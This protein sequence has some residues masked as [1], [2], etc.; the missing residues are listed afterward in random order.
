MSS[1]AS[2]DSTKADAGKI[3]P[4]LPVIFTPA[5]EAEPDESETA[6]TETTAPPSRRPWTRHAPL[7]ASLA[8]ALLVGGLAGAAATASFM[9]GPSTHGAAEATHALQHSVVQLSTEI[10]ALK[11]SV[12][13]AQRTTNTQF[14]KF[15]ARLDRTEKAQTEPT[16]KLAKLQESVDALAKQQQTA[17]AAAAPPAAASA[18]ITGSVAAKQDT[19]PALDGWRLRDFYSGRAVVES[20]AGTLF[21]V[22]PG[23]NVPGLGKVE[24]IRR[25]NGRIIVVTANGTISGTI[26]PRRPRY[27]MPYRY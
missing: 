15:S 2:A 26:E 10:T 9:R 14:D 18:E 16:Q 12:I 25:D 27:S 23:S 4:F 1:S 7:A 3:G 5:V 24:T 11:A 20:R 21:E 6:E 13:A 8:L 22:G 17:A 19:R